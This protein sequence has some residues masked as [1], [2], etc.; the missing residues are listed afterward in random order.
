MLDL[1][2]VL[3][4]RDF[5]DSHPCI[6]FDARTKVL[7]PLLDEV[8]RDGDQLGI[9]LENGLFFN[10]SYKSNIAKE[11]LLRDKEVPDHVWEPMTTRSVELA[12]RYRP[13]PVLIGGAYFGDHALV[14]AHEISAANRSGVVVCVEPNQQQ[15]EILEN[16]AAIN[17]LSGYISL[18]DSVLW[19]ISGL[20]FDLLATDSHASVFPGGSSEYSSKTI[21]EILVDH[22]LREIS[23][24]LLDIEGSEEQALRGATS[25]LSLPSDQAPVVITEIHRKY[26]DWSNGLEKTPIVSCLLGHGYH[27]FALRDCQSNWSLGLDSPEIIP[28]DRVCLEGPPHG[29]NLIAAKDAGFFG[30][31]RF[32]IVHDVSPKYL[33]HRDPAIHFPLP[34]D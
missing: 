8:F 6:G 21:D 34:L 22:G 32:R 7:Y 2:Y 17:N 24:I 10:Y 29:F 5:L 25:A 15:R 33:R 1:S 11:I 9:R 13:G 16:N 14:A 31:Q 12:L 18:L 20:K 30:D 23:L 3:S 19:S 4:L 27:V 28:L 26:V